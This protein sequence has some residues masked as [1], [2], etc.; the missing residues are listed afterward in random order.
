[1]NKLRVTNSTVYLKYAVQ[2]Y[3]LISRNTA[4][5]FQN[6]LKGNQDRAEVSF[7]N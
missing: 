4:V 3:N 1:M 6:Q 5:I 7:G 2:V